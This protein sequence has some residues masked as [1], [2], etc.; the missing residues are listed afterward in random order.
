[1]QDIGI[2]LIFKCG[3]GDYNCGMKMLRDTTRYNELVL[4]KTELENERRGLKMQVRRLP[5]GC[6]EIARNGKY[7]QWRAALKGKDGAM[8]IEKYA[9]HVRTEKIGK[10]GEKRYLVNIPKSQSEL[11]KKL[12]KGEYLRKRISS[13]D[14][15]MEVLNSYIE[16]LR[17]NIIN[18]ENLVNV[19]E[20]RSLLAELYSEE[21][22]KIRKWEQLPY[23]RNEYHSD[24]KKH[25]TSK[26]MKGDSKSEEKL[27]EE[28]GSLGFGIWHE[29]RVIIPG[30]VDKYGAQQYEYPDVVLR[31]PVTGRV[32][33]VEHC[34]LLD[35]IKYIFKT[36]RRLANYSRIGFLIGKDIFFTSETL[37]RPLCGPE[38]KAL[39][40]YISHNYENG[41]TWEEFRRLVEIEK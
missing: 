40:D 5:K 31:H 24:R 35:D 25:E 6:L 33:I 10:D 18:E 12:V 37:E 20:K 38:V 14:R 29:P 32:F 2:R 1:M 30:V 13:I 39:A 21:K 11:A 17:K 22:E 4:C 41:M 26:K 34:G 23:V 7:I 3:C 19:E 16:V 27:M 28:F 9:L 15:I 8:L 36:S